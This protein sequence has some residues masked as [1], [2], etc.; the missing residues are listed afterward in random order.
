MIN[1]N[2]CSCSDGEHLPLPLITQ[3]LLNS[4]ASLHLATLTESTSPL[5]TFSVSNPSQTQTSGSIFTYRPS[6]ADKFWA[7]FESFVPGNLPVYVFGEEGCPELTPDCQEVAIV[8]YNFAKRSLWRWPWTWTDI[9]VEPDSFYY[10][11]HRFKLYL[12]P[13]VA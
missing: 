13:T 11:W 2:L 1:Y 10:Q 6:Y 7:S 9:W 5:A 8:C 4:G 3:G 12:L